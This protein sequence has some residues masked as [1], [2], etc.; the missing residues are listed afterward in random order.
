MSNTS[1]LT[2]Y[3]LSLDSSTKTRVRGLKDPGC[4]PYFL[5]NLLTPMNLIRFDC[6][7]MC[8]RC[9]LYGVFKRLGL[10][11]TLKF[12]IKSFSNILKFYH[13]R[14]V[15]SFVSRE[16]FCPETCPTCRY[17]DQTK[18]SYRVTIESNTPHRL[19]GKSELRLR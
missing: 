3:F 12:W 10:R 13:F 14:F 1:K 9:V 11:F 6:F 19:V 17:F 16:D 8:G 2:L 7:R 18:G 4:P 5:D 15:V